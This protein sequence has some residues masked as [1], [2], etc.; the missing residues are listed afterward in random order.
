M[1]LGGERRVAIL[2]KSPRLRVRCRLGFTIA[3]FGVSFAAMNRE[4]H[5]SSGNDVLPNEPP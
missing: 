3:D 2:Y 1:S 4:S 5:L